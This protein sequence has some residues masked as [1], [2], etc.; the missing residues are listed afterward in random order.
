MLKKD[1]KNYKK[2]C[3]LGSTR[4]KKH[5]LNLVLTVKL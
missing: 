1:K 5:V 3:I 2:C 4:F